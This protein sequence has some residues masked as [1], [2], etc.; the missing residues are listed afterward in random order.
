[1]A[2]VHS[3]Q[4]CTGT[5][6]RRQ[7]RRWK[8]LVSAPTSM[9]KATTTAP[10]CPPPLCQRTRRLYLYIFRCTSHRLVGSHDAATGG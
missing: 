6:C 1:M 3:A 2:H 4:S 9:R 5:S 7:P 8:L 10:S